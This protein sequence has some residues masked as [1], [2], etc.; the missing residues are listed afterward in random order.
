MAILNLKDKAEVIHRPSSLNTNEIS[1]EMKDTSS[2]YKNEFV[3]YNHKNRE[4]KRKNI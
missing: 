1:E 4:L 2:L 3:Y